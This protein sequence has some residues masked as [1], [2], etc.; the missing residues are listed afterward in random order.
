MKVDEDLTLVLAILSQNN[1]KQN[2]R[3]SGLVPIQFPSLVAYF[4]PFDRI[5]SGLD[6][7]ARRKPVWCHLVLDKIFVSNDFR[8]NTYLLV[9]GRVCGSNRPWEGF[10]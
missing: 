10:N 7:H 4:I 6:G 3:P 5:E 9:L 2:L 1:P 8:D